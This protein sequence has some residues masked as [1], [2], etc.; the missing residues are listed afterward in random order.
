[1]IFIRRSQLTRVIS[2]IEFI[3]LANKATEKGRQQY[4]AKQHE[5]IAAG[6]NLVEID[7]LRAG[8]WIMAAQEDGYP[9][10]LQGPYRISVVRA[11]F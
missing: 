5:L 4:F 2:V 8:G 11:T 1:V 10:H 9:P 6:V 7:L 3:S